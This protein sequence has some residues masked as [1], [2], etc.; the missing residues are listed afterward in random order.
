[1]IAAAARVT[2]AWLGTLGRPVLLRAVPTWLGLG[3]VAGVT[4]QGNALTAADLVAVARSSTRALLVMG[5]AWLILS[6][7]AV[8]AAID[9]PGAAYL[10]ALPGGRRVEPAAIAALAAV[11]GRARAGRRPP[12]PP[13]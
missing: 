9:P 8:R 2:S 11:A 12:P 5:T 10:R 1:M 3:I 6:A 7:A 13:G 4:M